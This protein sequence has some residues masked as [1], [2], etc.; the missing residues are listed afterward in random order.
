M[1]LKT[2][3]MLFA[4]CSTAFFIISSI[5][6][7]P[8][9]SSGFSSGSISI[10]FLSG[11]FCLTGSG[12][13]CCWPTPETPVSKNN[14]MAASTLPLLSV[15]NWWMKFLVYLIS[16]KLEACSGVTPV[17]SQTTATLSISI[18]V[19]YEACR[20]RE[21]SAALKLTRLIYDFFFLLSE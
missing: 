8:N 20:E 11:S 9:F 6:D 3:P 2:S 4:P 16:N 19:F 17:T 14:P 12:W 13:F 15:S 21:K 10:V 18:P 1:I 7:S 5:E